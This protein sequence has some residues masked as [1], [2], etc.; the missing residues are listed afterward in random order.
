[1]KGRF[2]ERK[3]ITIDKDKCIGCQLCV[4]AC[5]EGAIG[6]VDGKATLCVMIIAMD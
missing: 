5:Q 1:M 2:Y 6:M 4:N 3:I